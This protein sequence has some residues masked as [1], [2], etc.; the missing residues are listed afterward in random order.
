M[1]E[2]RVGGL[3]LDLHRR[4]QGGEDPE[5]TPD[6]LVPT[7]RDEQ[8]A[9]AAVLGVKEVFFL[10]NV[11]GEL[12]YNK[13]FM[14]E[15]VRFIRRLKPYAVISH[16]P[17]Q[18]VRNAFI[19]HPD[20][21]ATGEVTLDAVYPIARNRPSFPELLEEG[22]SHTACARSTSERLDTNFDVDIT[23]VLETKFGALQAR[24]TDWRDGGAARAADA[25][26]A[27]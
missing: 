23:E 22:L 14:R 15:V 13:D 2:G 1:G 5:W 16:D 12:T 17:N 18:I 4:F 26:L 19:N 24:D 8:R 7:R 10:D 20:H 25:I 6:K 3:L 11:D 21:R 27:R 9:A